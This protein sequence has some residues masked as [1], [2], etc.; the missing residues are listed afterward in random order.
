LSSSGSLKTKTLI[1][2]EK[3]SVA[4][5]VKKALPGPWRTHEGIHESAGYVV[6]AAA[7][8]L[9]ELAEP[10][11]YDARYET[12]RLDDLPI[13]P[14]QLEWVPRDER[15]AKRL[16]RL[17]QTLEREDVADVINACDAG[18][19]GELIFKVILRKAPARPGKPIRRAWF[20]AMTAGEIRRAFGALRP[21]TE[22][23]GLEAA[24][25]ARQEADWL[26]GINSTRAL[27]IGAGARGTWSLGRVQT[28][29]LRLLVERERLIDE[30]VPRRYWRVTGSVEV[31]GRE[32]SLYWLGPDEGRLWDEESAHAVET[33]LAGAGTAVVIKAGSEEEDVPAPRLFDLTELQAACSRR[34]GWSAKRTLD[35]AQACYEAG[36]LTYPRT[37]SRFLPPSLA[38]RLLSILRRLAEGDLSVAAQARALAAGGELPL[39]QVIWS[40]RV[41]DHHAI[42][43]T[44][45]VKSLPGLTQDARRCYDLVAIRFVAALSNPARLR[46]LNLAVTAAAE[47]LEGRLTQVADRGWWTVEPS[48]R[49]GSASADPLPT[50]ETSQSLPLRG[51]ARQECWVRAPRPYTDGE[52]VQAMARAGHTLEE[53]AARAALEER[54]IGT[55]AT[56]AQIIENLIGR[57]YLAREGK[58]LIPTALGQAVISALGD[59]RLSEVRLT[60]DWEARL[61]AIERGDESPERFRADIRTFTRDIVGALGTLGPISP[62]ATDLAACPR[63][64]GRVVARA[65][66]FVCTNWTASGG[67]GCDFV[68]FRWRGKRRV[69]RAEAVQRINE[70]RPHRFRRP[71][72]VSEPTPPRGPAHP[73]LEN[74]MPY[75]PWAGARIPGL[76]GLDDGDLDRLILDVV[77]AEGPILVRRIT[78]CLMSVGGIN[79]ETKRITKRVNR[80][81]ARLERAGA[82]T[83][84]DDLSESPQQGRVLSMPGQP[85]VQH[86]RRGP[87]RIDEIPRTELRA[88]A[89]WLAAK[90]QPSGAR[91]L[92]LLYEIDPEEPGQIEA[93]QNQLGA[94]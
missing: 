76:E 14:E 86:R 65:R 47:R 69:G 38:P 54:G 77:V 48:R 73:W 26:V 55:P 22:M 89:A 29:T 53:T 6:A 71:K 61:A 18:R 92:A 35:A 37:D 1:I 15:A 74:V 19:E 75:S 11:H 25:F 17:W 10:A 27:T 84:C 20:V 90:E 87:R 60:A 70:N 66:S 82:L 7:G 52:L 42:I 49:A 24:A 83:G 2:C 57:R 32:W 79:R 58:Y 4:L 3:S 63:C 30:Y 41:R 5:A 21:D 59:N 85:S 45:D 51:V 94:E 33:R 8:H 43:P 56:R 39:R 64:P 34:F 23:R 46:H 78:R 68:V 62:P 67:A 9:L 31:G 72:P 91:A 40:E 80:A 13:L 81:S 36:V 93:L 12:W 28:P 88:A 16:A 44:E 50:V